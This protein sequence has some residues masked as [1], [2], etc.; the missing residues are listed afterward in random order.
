M[1]AVLQR[2]VSAVGKAATEIV[3]MER[4]SGE[5]SAPRKKLESDGSEYFIRGMWEYFTLKGQ[6]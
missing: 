3:A 4:S 2:T 1:S 6:K 5:E